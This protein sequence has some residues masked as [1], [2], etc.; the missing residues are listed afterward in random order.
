MSLKTKQCKHGTFTF[1][2]ND[3]YI[4]KQL[5]VLGYYSEGEVQLLL[6]LTTPGMTVVDVGANIGAITVPWARK[7]KQVWAFEPQGEIFNV[8]VKNLVMNGL[9][10]VRAH[11]WGLNSLKRRMG[12]GPYDMEMNDANTGAVPL[13]GFWMNENEMVWTYPLDDIVKERVDIIK[14]D[15]EGMELEVLKGAART[16]QRDW[17]ILYLENN[18]RSPE[19][20]QYIL[21]L[22]YGMAWHLPVLECL[23]NKDAGTRTLTLSSNMI[24]VP[25]GIQ[26]SISGE[27]F[28]PIASAVDSDWQKHPNYAQ[29]IV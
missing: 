24:C 25:P 22:G 5:D 11:P 16:I 8:L 4:G 3:R 2:D 23:V 18:E 20:I 21:D 7:A 19:L 15:V 17:P 26:V 1:F 12:V 9:Y 6:S 29:W 13:R 28:L 27:D 14:I 10:N